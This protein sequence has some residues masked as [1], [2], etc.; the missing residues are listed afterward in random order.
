M[1][2]REQHTKPIKPIII[3]CP[4]T[5]HFFFVVISL[6]FYVKPTLNGP[7]NQQIFGNMILI[8]N[9][10]LTIFIQAVA[11]THTHNVC[12]TLQQNHSHATIQMSWAFHDVRSKNNFDNIFACVC[13]SV[14]YV[15]ANVHCSWKET[16]WHVDW[17]KQLLLSFQGNFLLWS[18]L[19]VI[20]WNCVSV[21][22]CRTDLYFFSRLNIQYQGNQI[23]T[24][25]R[26]IALA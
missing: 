19:Y 17:T 25:K 11:R 8:L 26:S 1:W 15:S 5:L 2:Q 24:K 13:V 21:C 22:R 9:A 14:C 4:A 23:L 12:H 6:S 7:K 3:I 10:H 16:V 20:H 18:N